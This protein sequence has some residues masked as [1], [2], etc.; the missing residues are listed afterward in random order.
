MRNREM[1]LQT[2]SCKFFC[3]H[4]RRSGIEGDAVSKVSRYG[5]AAPASC[6]KPEGLFMIL[7]APIEPSLRSGTTR[8]PSGF[9]IT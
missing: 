8:V 4:F 7:R 6:D 9:K 5:G 1:S 3:F 2:N